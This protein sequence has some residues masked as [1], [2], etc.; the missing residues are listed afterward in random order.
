MDAFPAR[1]AYMGNCTTDCPPVN[2]KGRFC[3]LD[4]DTT[5][6]AVSFPEHVSKSSTTLPVLIGFTILDQILNDAVVMS[7]SFILSDCHFAFPQVIMLKSSLGLL[8]E[9]G[10]GLIYI[11]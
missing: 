3:Q 6:S 11:P 2:H 5:L 4:A 1:L 10:W 8:D 9:V 7:Q